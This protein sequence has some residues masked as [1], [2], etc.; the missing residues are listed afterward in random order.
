MDFRKVIS[1]V[2]HNMMAGMP[3]NPRMGE[4]TDLASMAVFLASDQVSFVNGAVLSLDGGWT[5]Y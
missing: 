3:L 5:A 1:L 2:N 4:P